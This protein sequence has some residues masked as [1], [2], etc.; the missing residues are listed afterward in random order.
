MEMQETKN[1]IPNGAD[2]SAEPRGV[3]GASRESLAETTRQLRGDAEKLV[4]HVRQVRGEL[5]S[6]ISQSARE[7]PVA[8]LATAAGV[9]YLLGG[10]L[11]SRLT[12]VMIGLATRFAMAVAAH[13][14]GSWATEP[15]FS[16][17]PSP[18][19]H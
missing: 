2:E 11:G 15:Q 10:G 6:Y 7:R 17:T 1:A 3:G 5:E 16:E 12:V 14:V 8:T 19:R 13:E 4:G 18:T 9:G